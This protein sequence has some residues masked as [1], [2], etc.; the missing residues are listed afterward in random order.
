M[1]RRN[2]RAARCSSKKQPD[3]TAAP[4][5]PSQTLR[6]FLGLGPLSREEKQCVRELLAEVP[7]QMSEREGE[8]WDLEWS[9]PVGAQEADGRQSA[10]QGRE[11]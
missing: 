5:P 3:S 6:D 10:G 9:S 7:R 4:P 8:S 1:G 2:R 11:L